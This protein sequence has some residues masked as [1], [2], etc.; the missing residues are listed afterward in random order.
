MREKELTALVCEY[1]LHIKG[2]QR[3]KKHAGK[4]LNVK[5]EEKNVPKKL[6]SEKM[7]YQN[8]V[9]KCHHT[10]THYTP[11]KVIFLLFKSRC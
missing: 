8:V 2:L 9:I 1:Y 4:K 3:M 10:Y 5:N 6:S 7:K 11:F